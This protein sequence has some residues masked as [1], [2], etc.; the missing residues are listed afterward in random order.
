MGDA[1]YGAE[2][3]LAQDGESLPKPSRHWACAVSSRMISA[4][5]APSAMAGPL[6][7]PDTGSGAATTARSQG[8][9]QAAYG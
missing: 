1:T 6:V 4:A 2:T 3:L 7:L 9:G 5:R 8:L